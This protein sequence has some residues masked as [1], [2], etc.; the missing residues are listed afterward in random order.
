MVSGLA[1]ELSTY[2]EGTPDDN[3][4]HQLIRPFNRGFSEA[5]RSTAPRLS[6]FRRDDREETVEGLESGLPFTHPE[7][8]T[9]AIEPEIYNDD[10]DT[11]CVDEVMEMADG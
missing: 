2:V 1:R 3:G 6:P 7:C 9:P 10:V 8:F 4:I 5:I 11:I